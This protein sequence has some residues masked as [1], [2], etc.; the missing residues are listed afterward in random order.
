[1]NKLVGLL[2][3]L[4][5]SAFSEEI[6]FLHWWTSKGELSALSVIEGR[7]Y[8]SQYVIKSDP[9]VGGGGK[10]AKSTLQ[11]RTIAGN[12]P[13]MALMEGPAI[14][15]WA[16]LGF[17][18]ELDDISEI[19]TW[20]KF[21]YDDIKSINKYNGKYV[22][23]PLNIHRLNWMWINNEVLTKFDLDVPHNWDS[24]INILKT[25]KSSGVEPIAL[26]NDQWQIVQ[27]FENIAFG[28]GGPDYYM[29]AFVDLDENSL[30]SE[31]TELVFKRFREI[32]KI[33]ASLLPTMTWDEGVAA[34]IRGDRAF[35]FT[36]DWALG[37][38]L[39]NKG[40]I[41]EHILCVPFPSIKPGFI[42]NSDSLVFFKKFSE[43][44]QF[45]ESILENIS[46]PLFIK[47]MNK[48]KGSIPA[49][50]NISI[51][52]FSE[53][54]KKSYLD[55]HQAK[56]DNAIV[57]SIVDSMAVDPVIQNAVANEVYRYFLDESIDT[58]KVIH[59][60]LSIRVKR[61]N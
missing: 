57:P 18:L 48:R 50:H 46:S 11:F 8:D 1:M 43:K 29:K 5:S 39:N 56:R 28:V 12:P 52:D 6:E 17:L 40:D 7:F 33:N 53:C 20:D 47:E 51:D 13:N 31:T 25:L 15:S 61:L 30:G 34:L 42:Y 60:L 54:Q 55:Y 26:G 49:Q 35:Q 41:P 3:F 45:P 19:N 59:R 16:A 36:G 2:L 10:V 44:E 21:L 4:S 37:E 23:I 9:I 32:S 58:Q 27:L 14:S 38:M 24:L 22:A